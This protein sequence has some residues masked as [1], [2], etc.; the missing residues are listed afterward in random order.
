MKNAIIT[1]LTLAVFALSAEPVMAHGR[2]DHQHRGR[3]N[4]G[5]VAVAIGGAIVL[6]AILNNNQPVDRFYDPR[7][8]PPV[9]MMSRVCFE[10]QIVQRV[11]GF[12]V[13]HYQ[14]RCR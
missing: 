4:V 3:V 13:I 2:G 7:F 1:A 8:G 9:G 14:Y 6:G 11:N 5:D 10:E 12:P